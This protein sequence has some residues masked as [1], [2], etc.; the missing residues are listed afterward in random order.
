MASN[1]P[2]FIGRV[3]V[4]L[5]EELRAIVLSLQPEGGEEVEFCMVAMLA[6]D[7][8]N[9]LLRLADELDPPPQRVQ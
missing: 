7:I 2:C 6:R 4:A 9:E 1:R 3:G 5:D 8:G